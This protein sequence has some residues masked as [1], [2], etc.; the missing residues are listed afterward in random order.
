VIGYHHFKI[1]KLALQF[2]DN[3]TGRQELLRSLSFSHWSGLSFLYL[4]ASFLHC[5][6]YRKGSLFLQRLRT[7]IANV[8]GPVRT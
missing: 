6:L 3:R 1:C 4:L 7:Q 8:R 5:D 2:G